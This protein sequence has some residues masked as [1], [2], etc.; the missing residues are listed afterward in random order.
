MAAVRS[1]LTRIPVHPWD[2]E[3]VEAHARSRVGTKRLRRSAGAF[4]ITIAAH[5]EALGVTLVTSDAAVKNLKIDGLK[6]VSW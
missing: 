4:D 6:I 3:A 2:E 5:A 1:F